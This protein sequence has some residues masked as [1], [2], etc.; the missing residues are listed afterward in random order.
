MCDEMYFAPLQLKAELPILHELWASEK[1]VY[2]FEKYALF[3]I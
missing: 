1:L 3:C 2:W